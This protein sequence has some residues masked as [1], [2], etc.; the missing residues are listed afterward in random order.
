MGASTGTDNRDIVR[1]INDLTRAVEKNTKEQKRT[2]EAITSLVIQQQN[3]S[4]DK[5]KNVESVPGQ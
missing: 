2:Y 5:E 3:P 4:E 1:A